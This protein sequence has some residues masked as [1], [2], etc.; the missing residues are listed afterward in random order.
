MKK[1]Y[2]KILLK[3]YG[4]LSSYKFIT[5][6]FSCCNRKITS[7]FGATFRLESRNNFELSCGIGY[8]N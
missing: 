7:D 8:I 4:V 3:C 2:E 5:D 1:F 6:G